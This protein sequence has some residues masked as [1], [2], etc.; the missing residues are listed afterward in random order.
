[1]NFPGELMDVPLGFGGK[2]FRE[3][4]HRKVWMFL[5]LLQHHDDDDDVCEEMNGSEKLVNG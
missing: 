5:E 3:D 4:Y 1:M 2:L